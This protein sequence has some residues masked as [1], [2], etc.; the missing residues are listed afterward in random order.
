MEAKHLTE[1]QCRRRNKGESFRELAQDIR[2]LMLLSYPNERSSMSENMMKE[3]FIAAIDDPELE[4]KVRDKEPKNIDAAQ[5]YAER[6]E[7][8]KG[9]VHQGHRRNAKRVTASPDSRSSSL[10]ERTLKR[11]YSR[12]KSRQRFDESSS[13]SSHKDNETRLST[14]HDKKEGRNDDRRVCAVN[15]DEK[16]K[17]ELLKK[18]QELEFNQQKMAAENKDFHLNQ[19]KIL[20]ENS[21]LSKEVERLRYLEQLRSVTAPAS[22]SVAA[23]VV[24]PLLPSGSASQQRVC[25]A[26]NNPGHMAKNCL[27]NAA[28][29]RV[30]DHTRQTYEPHES[31]NPNHEA[32]LRVAIDSQVYDCLL[33]TESGVSL[34]PE[35]VIGSAVVKATN[36]T[37]KAANGSEIPI[38]GEVN[39]TVEIGSYS[40]QVVGLV[41]DRIPEPVLGLDFFI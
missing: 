25:F 2:R 6:L 29:R 14:K 17:E 16:W 15:V 24:K 7:F 4:L 41:S 8:Y 33:D 36:R 35:H 20:A 11:D 22:T 10:E 26:S 37:L 30:D 40:T 5:N 31:L 27:Q 13:Q 23:P 12:S 19:Q 38:L 21:A 28:A 34:F 18:V 3:N 39:L 9:A 1:L 32:F